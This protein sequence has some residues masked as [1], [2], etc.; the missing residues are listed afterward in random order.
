MHACIIVVGL[1]LLLHDLEAGRVVA[2]RSRTLD[3]ADHEKSRLYICVCAWHIKK[4]GVI[5]TTKLPVAIYFVEATLHAGRDRESDRCYI[6][7]FT[8][9]KGVKRACT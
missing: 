8:Q 3:D 7:R 4:L 9:I 6:K 2:C 5:G 1:G